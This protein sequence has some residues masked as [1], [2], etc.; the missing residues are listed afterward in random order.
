MNSNFHSLLEDKS[1]VSKTHQ[2]LM[3]RTNVT[4]HQSSRE[5]AINSSKR[6]GENNFGGV[7]D[8]VTVWIKEHKIL[9]YS[10]DG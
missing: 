10:E 5:K 1:V 3:G 6:K 8:I 4:S 9:I 7:R 2:L